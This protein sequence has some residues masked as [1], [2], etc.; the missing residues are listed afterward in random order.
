MKKGIYFIAVGLFLL[1]AGIS[2]AEVN[3]EEGLW[4]ITST[5]DM[6]G[7]GVPSRTV[8]NTT[9][10]TK[11]KAVPQKSES[12][13]TMKDIK[14]QG[15]TVTWTIICKEA[16]SKGKVTYVGSTMDGV[17]ETTVKTEG[18][19]MTMKSTLKGK[20]LGPCK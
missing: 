20:R 15:N 6:P 7:M 17:M 11:E 16:I 8:T 13:C 5:V 1:V 19:T 14:T 9:C 12:G 18:Q 3:M 4:Q 2:F 10:I